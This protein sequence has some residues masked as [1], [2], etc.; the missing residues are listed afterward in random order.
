[1]GEQDRRTDLVE[2]RRAGVAIELL[3]LGKILQRRKLRCVELVKDGVT[4]LRRARPLGVQMRLR[5]QL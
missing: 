4:R 2:Q 1:V 5:P 3:L